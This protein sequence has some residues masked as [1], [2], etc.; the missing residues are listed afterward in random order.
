MS[1]NPDVWGIRARLLRWSV[2]YLAVALA[3]LLVIVIEGRPEQ[4]DFWTEF[5]VAL[6]FVSLAM[7]A[8]QSAL[9][10]RISKVSATIGQDT[11]LQFHRQAGLVAFALLV[12]HPVL[13]VLAEA[14]N[15]AFLDPR[16]NPLRA[17]ALWTVLIAFPGLLLTSLW[18]QQ[19]RLP[20]EW[21]RLGHGVVAV[22]LVLIGLAHIFQ[23]SYYLAS[24]WQRGLWLVLGAGSV[25][26]VVSV[27]LLSPWRAA[28][29]PY[30]VA[31]VRPLA[32]ATWSLTLSSET[33]RALQFRPGQFAF[34]TFSDSAYSLEQHPFSVASGSH[35]EDQLEFAVK[36][37]GDFTSTIGEVPEGSRAF[38]DGPYGGM[39]LSADAVGLFAVAGGIGISPVISMIRTVAATGPRMPIVLVYA[40]NRES[41]AAFADELDALSRDLGDEMLVIHVLNTPP[42]GWEGHIGVITPA[43]L[44]EVLPEEDRDRWQYVVCGPPPMMEVAERSL[45]DHGV[46]LER[47]DS[48]RF[49]IGAA[50]ATGR[51]NASV[52]RLVI[53]IG[54][55]LL[56]ASA[57][58]A[59]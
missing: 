33:G 31:E 59:L 18:R 3:P 1:P 38:V 58:Y 25:G 36:E 35:V 13:L 57:L 20:Y 32:D 34:V 17:V 40:N 46:P 23:V 6:G 56:G 39:T 52:R 16:P 4:R 42:E 7:M 48:E 2:L 9:T 51:R 28:R 27:R 29:A 47:I 55:V 45:L 43:M 26:F 15:W 37:L 50:A 30:R 14:D 49:D 19:L 5:G 24:P 41:D 21:W 11:L 44:G 53:V 54:T 8:M 12:G 22:L 10:A